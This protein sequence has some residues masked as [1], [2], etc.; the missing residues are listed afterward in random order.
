LLGQ[1]YELNNP[2]AL[3][4]VRVE[5]FSKASSMLSS[6]TPLGYAEIPLSTI[7]ADGS[8]ATQW[9]PLQKLPKMKA[10]SG[11]VSPSLPLSL[12][13]PGLTIQQIEITLKFSGPA[14]V[15]RQASVGNLDVESLPP[16]FAETPEDH[17]DAEPNELCIY[18]IAGRGL[19]A[20]DSF[21]FGFAFLSPLSSSL[22]HRP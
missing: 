9:Y 20:M 6:D 1:H 21:L 8:P 7:P 11:E 3:P 18:A 17:R 16:Q 15:Q 10:I 22:A 2:D 12:P 13:P 19:Q 4:T 14:N 5:V